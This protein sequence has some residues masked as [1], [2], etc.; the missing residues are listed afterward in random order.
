MSAQ[1]KERGNGMLQVVCS[2]GY[3]GTPSPFGL[4]INKQLKQHDKCGKGRNE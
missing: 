4:I 2:C 3:L 1:T